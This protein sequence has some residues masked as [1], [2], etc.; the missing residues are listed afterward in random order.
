MCLKEARASLKG[1]QTISNTERPFTHNVKERVGKMLQFGS[2]YYAW[3]VVC[4]EAGCRLS[5]G[6]FDAG[7]GWLL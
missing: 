4:R 7:S 2:A 3:S 6:M 1:A 5:A